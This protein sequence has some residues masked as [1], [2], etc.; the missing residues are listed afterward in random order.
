VAR[1]VK[2]WQW[3]MERRCR[4]RWAERTHRIGESLVVRK[5]T[6]VFDCPVARKVTMSSLIVL[7][8]RTLSLRNLDGIVTHWIGSSCSTTMSLGN[9][10]SQPNLGHGRTRSGKSRLK[11]TMRCSLGR[12]WKPRTPRLLSGMGWRRASEGDVERERARKRD[13]R[14]VAWV[15][16]HV[17]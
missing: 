16:G 15:R 14:D 3:L 7:P 6:W 4:P 10:H 9:W 5:R 17:D 8:L 13:E 11:R 1:N 12:S 2:C